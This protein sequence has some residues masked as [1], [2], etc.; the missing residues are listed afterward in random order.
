MEKEDNNFAHGL[1]DRAVKHIDT[2]INFV[3]QA[4]AN[5]HK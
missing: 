1:R 5:A 4:L 2:A 3:E